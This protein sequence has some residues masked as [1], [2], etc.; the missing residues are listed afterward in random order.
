MSRPHKEGVFSRWSRR[1]LGSARIATETV[2]PTVESSQQTAESQAK[3]TG[4]ANEADTPERGNEALVELP[5]IDELGPDSDFQGF[6]NPQVDDSLRRAALKKLFSDPHFN[7]TD[8]LDVYAEDYTKLES[9]TPAMV[10]GLKHTRGILFGDNDG[11]S[12]NQ[13]DTPRLSQNP[14]GAIADSAITDAPRA[15]NKED[16]ERDDSGPRSS[17]AKDDVAG[18]GDAKDTAIAVSSPDASVDESKA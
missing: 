18:D 3:G 11:D 16:A 10:A 15:T 13:A 6:M 9:L 4:D 17:E 7:V 1:K 8:G 2:E 12:N 14:Q 5:S